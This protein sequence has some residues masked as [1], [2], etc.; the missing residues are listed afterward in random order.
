MSRSITTP[1]SRQSRSCKA[2]PEFTRRDLLRA[3]LVTP[4]V[5]CTDDLTEP[6]STETATST[7]PPTFAQGVSWTSAVPTVSFS[8]GTAVAYDLKQHTLG[9]DSAKHEMALAADSASLPSGVTLDPTGLIKYDG[10]S[11][12]PAV[13]GI[14]IDIRDT[15]RPVG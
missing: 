6:A 12:V 9:F 8:Q 13:T 15:A 5:G 4:L 3:L 14:V 1:P 11:P 10:T 2:R 7:Q